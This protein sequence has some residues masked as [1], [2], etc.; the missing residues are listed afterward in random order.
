MS[1]SIGLGAVLF[2][3]SGL[4]FINSKSEPHSAS[5]STDNE[6]KESKTE[7]QKAMDAGGVNNPRSDIHVDSLTSKVPSS[8]GSVDPKRHKLPAKNPKDADG[9]ESWVTALGDS[10]EHSNLDKENQ[11]IGSLRETLKPDRADQLKGVEPGDH[12]QS[13]EFF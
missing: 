7:L 4:W 3:G 11:L 9:D 1:Y 10:V 5:E 8:Y 13:P 12:S 6:F 2:L